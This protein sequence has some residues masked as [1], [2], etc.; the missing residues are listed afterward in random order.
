[1]D[2]R[3]LNVHKVQCQDQHNFF[4]S[5]APYHNPGFCICI[6]QPANLSVVFITLQRHLSRCS[7]FMKWRNDAMWFPCVLQHCLL[8]LEF[9]KFKIWFHHTVERGK[10]ILFASNMCQYFFFLLNVYE[11]YS[12]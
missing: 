7:Q 5:F 9:E 10:E 4:S 1:M 8:P 6:L 2:S 11:D 3:F 12:L